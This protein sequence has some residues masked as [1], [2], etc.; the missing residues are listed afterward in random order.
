MNIA[1]GRVDGPF[2]LE[3]DWIGVECD[4]SFREEFAYETYQMPKYIVGV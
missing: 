1:A 2:S 4:H 3:L